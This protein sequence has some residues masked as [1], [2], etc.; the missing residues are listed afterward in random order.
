MNNIEYI[1]GFNITIIS[2]GV[3]S[4]YLNSFSNN[5]I[6]FGVRIPKRFI[7]MKELKDLEKEYKRTVLVSFLILIVLFNIV[8]F[9]NRNSSEDIVSIILGVT[10]ILSI[11]IHGIIY[12]V[13]NIKLKKI[14]ENNN[15]NYKGNNVVIVDTTLRKPKKDER[16]KPLKEWM[17]LIPIIIPIS[18][19]LLTYIR[20]NELIDSIFS[21]I[22]RFPLI[23]IIMCLFMYFLAKISLRSRVDLNSTNIES[24]ITYKKKIRRLIS[25]FFLINELEILILYSVIQFGIIYD[26]YS[27]KLISHINSF[28]SISMVIFLLVFITMGIKERD[29]KKN[30]NQ[31]EVYNDD[32]SKWILG[33]FYY[34]KKDPAFI[35]EKRVGLGYTINF[36][37]KFSLILLLLLILFSIFM[38]FI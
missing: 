4:Y 34:N 24:T 28:I 18:M 7:E 20:R 11:I 17:F 1:I 3:L 22:Y 38:A 32:D 16:Y 2:L 19:I 33:M 23:G 13:H 26:F 35:I 27:E 36:A 29:N 5:G 21:N 14:K 31:E 15:W 9:I 8:L 10:T 37:N 25:L 6:Y 12:S 30:D